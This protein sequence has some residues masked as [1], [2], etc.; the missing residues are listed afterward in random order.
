MEVITKM[1]T[2]CFGKK[3]AFDNY[4]ETIEQ[5]NKLT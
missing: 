2:F 1:G 4:E 5:M 3:N